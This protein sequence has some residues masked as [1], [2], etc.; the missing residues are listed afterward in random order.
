MP[1]KS[2]KQRRYLHMKHPQMARRWEHEEKGKKVEKS[3]F[4]VDH[5]Y[6]EKRKK[7]ASSKKTPPTTGR[8]VAG[9]L[10][11]PAHGVVAGRGVKGKAKTA[12]SQLGLATAG[13]IAGA[14]T[15]VPGLAFGGA[16]GGGYGATKIA[17]NKGWLKKQ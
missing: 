4:G 9:S 7:E 2:E 15:R 16:V 13:G 17:H 12:G 6:V 1:F 5:W 10:L 8:M 11:S 3:A 14:A